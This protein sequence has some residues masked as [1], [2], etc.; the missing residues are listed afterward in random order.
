MNKIYIV[1]YFEYPSDDVEYDSSAVEVAFTT[2]E[3]AEEYAADMNRK[4]GSPEVIGPDGLVDEGA[5]LNVDTLLGKTFWMVL[6][7]ELRD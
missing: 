6:E 4:H 5:L 1:N 2:R 7:V 3:K